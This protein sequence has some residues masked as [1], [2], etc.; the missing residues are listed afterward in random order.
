[1]GRGWIYVAESVR[2]LAVAPNAPRPPRGGWPLVY[3]LLAQPA[4]EAEVLREFTERFLFAGLLAL[5]AALVLGLVLA[6]SITRPLATLT[7]ATH[8]IA[9]GN[10]AHQ[11][12]LTGSVELRTLARDF[13]HMAGEIRRTQQAQHDF[14]A[15]VSHDLKTPLT[16]IQGFSQALLDGVVRDRAAFQDVAATIHAEALRMGRLVADVVDLA[17]LQS[18][19]TPLDRQ[20]VAVE[21]LLRQVAQGMLPQAIAGQVALQVES[22]PVPL[23]PADADQLHRALTNLLDNALRHT[24]PA[25]RVTLGAQAGPGSVCVYV[26][27]TGAGIPAHDLPRVFERFY[28]VD[29]SRAATGQG[30]GLGLAIVQEIVAA[31]GGAIAVQSAP[32]QGTEFTINLPL[33]DAPLVTKSH[34]PAI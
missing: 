15:N 29:K 3:V 17:R 21:P 33:R 9:A 31:H 6:R 25:G 16:S 4:P 11:A 13:N 7:A 1:M 8:E 24:P 2:S 10:Y 26:R 14:L 20:P 22:T 23:V 32:G 12:P 5:G 27:D 28:Q 19:E 34:T 30:S 18:G